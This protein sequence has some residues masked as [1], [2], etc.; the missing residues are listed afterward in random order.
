MIF[1]MRNRASMYEGR[2]EALGEEDVSRSPC[3]DQPA[4]S[5]RCL[6][7]LLFAF[8]TTC[9]GQRQCMANVKSTS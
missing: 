3:S 9:D 2:A 6:M 4:I 1:D 5:H 8:L 7:S